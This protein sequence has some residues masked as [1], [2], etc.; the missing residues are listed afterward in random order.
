MSEAACVPV[1]NWKSNP[2]RRK[3][4]ELLKE[5]WGV[6]K[7]LNCAVMMGRLTAAPERKHTPNNIAVTGFSVAGNRSYAK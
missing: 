7:M 6:E 4:L 1:R 3:N 2:C 5:S